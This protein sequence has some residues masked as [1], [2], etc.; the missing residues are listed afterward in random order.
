VGLL[1]ITYEVIQNESSWLKAIWGGIGEWGQPG[2]NASGSADYPID[3]GAASYVCISSQRKDRANCNTV[4]NPRS[5]DAG[6]IQ[7]WAELDEEDT[8]N[9]EYVFMIRVK[10][11]GETS[12]ETATVA[13][14]VEPL[15]GDK[16]IGHANGDKQSL[17]KEG[18]LR[19]TACLTRGKKVQILKTSLSVGTNKKGHEARARQDAEVTTAVNIGPCKK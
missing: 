1:T 3:G 5:H 2:F 6:S 16:L 15:G 8:P 17:C 10:I 12:G 9:C 13:F 4:L 7:I 18:S 11:M 14:S 19:A